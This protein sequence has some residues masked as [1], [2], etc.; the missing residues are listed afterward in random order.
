M[1]SLKDARSR[2]N[3]RKTKAEENEGELPQVGS[4][5]H[6]NVDMLGDQD[7]AYVHC[8][9]EGRGIWIVGVP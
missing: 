7:N 2:Q 9:V 1:R 4:L 8:V 5:E 6:V 3:K